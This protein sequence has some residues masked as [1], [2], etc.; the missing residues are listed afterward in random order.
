MRAGALVLGLSIVVAGAAAVDQRQAQDD[1]SLRTD[2]YGDRLPAGAVARIGTVRWWHGRAGYGPLVYTPDGK[3]LIS[4]EAGKAIRFFDAATGRETRRIEPGDDITSF[5]MAPDGKWLITAGSQNPALRLW[6][7]SIGKERRAIPAD[8]NGTSATAVSANGK[9]FAA[10]AH[11]GTIRVWDVATWREI[12]RLPMRWVESCAFLPDGN[13]LI[14]AGDGIR[15]WDVGSGREIRHLPKQVDHQ[16]RLVV[17]P[18]G[19]RLAAVVKP[20]PLQ[21][22][23]ATTGKEIRQAPLGG[24]GGVWCLCFSPDG[25]M[26]ACSGGVAGRIAPHT[27]FFAAD[28]GRELRNWHEDAWVEHLAFSP[29]GKTLAQVARERIRLRDVATGKPAFPMPGLPEYAMSVRFRADGKGLVVSCFGGSTGSW[30]P[31]SG[32]RLAALRAPPKGFSGRAEMLLGAALTADGKKAA[33]V[34]GRGALHVWVP[35]SGKVL[36]LIDNPPVGED[37]AEFSADGQLVVVKHRDEVI[38]LWEAD[39]GKLRCA[40][41]RYGRHRFP[42]PHAFSPDGRVLATAPSSLDQSVIR[43][44]D[45]ATG[46][47]TGRL[48]WQDGSSPTCVLFSGDGK[49]LAAA[50]G[51]GSM[52]I[53]GG[54]PV[55]DSLRLWD[56]RTGREVWRSRTRSGDIRALAISPDGKTLAAAD[57]DRI[58]L[59]EVA[60]GRERGRFTGHHE[61][62]WSLAFSPD[63]LLLASGSLDYTALVWDMTGLCPGGVWSDRDVG[64]DEL[65]RLWRDLAA[66]DADR[67]Y[68]AMW[69]MVGA[70]RSAVPFL[71]GRLRPVAQVDDRRLAALIADLDSRPFAARERASRELEALDRLAEPGLRRALKGRPSAEARKRIE[72]LLAKLDAAVTSPELL[73]LLRAVEALENIGTPPAGRVLAALARGAEARLTEEAQASLARLTRR[74]PAAP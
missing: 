18:D 57:H 3:T 56:V 15:W 44:W 6:D 35:A 1:R 28:T 47:E 22:W 11:D 60:S 7:V 63:G 21:L 8:A 4:C 48:A 41:P 20:G 58:V 13:T 67:A 10:A 29:D 16:R 43:L 19:R 26:L 62:V 54:E 38:R 50:H 2:R 9:R 64:R 24:P 34:D 27:R 42:L 51:G 55:E 14:A 37:Q 25:R 40:L 49:Y 17:S 12:R 36:C 52:T 32:R 59:R 66:T 72:R 74:A 69:A 65:Q 39:T 30:G 53:E 71:A 33:L 5:A 61:W 23:D 46:K 73:R 70:S 31:L 68:R 45:P